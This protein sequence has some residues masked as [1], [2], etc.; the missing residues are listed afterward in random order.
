MPERTH[1]PSR[2]GTNIS[3]AKP[4]LMFKRFAVF[5]A[6]PQALPLL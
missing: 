1:I 5:A 4:E 2:I 3:A 6:C